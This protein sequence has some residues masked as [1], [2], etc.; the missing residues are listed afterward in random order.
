M[1]LALLCCVLLAA[2]PA[3]SA[4]PPP[5]RA[6]AQPRWRN[7]DVVL[8]TSGSAQS[9][10]IQVATRSPY[11]HTGLVEVAPDGVFVIE[12]LGKV[13]RTPISAWIR[14][15]EGRKYTALRRRDLSD[16]EAA[17]VVQSARGF[18]G[19]R[20][21]ARFQW[22]DD[23]IYCSELVAKAY[24]RGAGKSAGRLQRIRDLDIAP[25]LAAAKARY[26]DRLPLD[27]QVLTPASLAEDAAFSALHDD[28][29]PAR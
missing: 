23:R 27:R 1:R 11:S 25:I 28:F 5:R 16:T 7:G 19:K 10:A 4:S 24:A 22:S 29:H 3:L 14:R 20:Y 13:S 21:D 17:A 26:G 8:Q 18:L 9:A 12:A 15:G 6:A 2:R